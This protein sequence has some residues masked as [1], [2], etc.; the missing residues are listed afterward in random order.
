[1]KKSKNRGSKK[2]KKVP[3]FKYTIL[4]IG[5]FLVLF[6]GLAINTDIRTFLTRAA[7]VTFDQ[8]PTQKNKRLD[9]GNNERSEIV[10]QSPTPTLKPGTT[11]GP[12]PDPINATVTPKPVPT[13]GQEVCRLDG[14]TT[15]NCKCQDMRGLK[16]AGENTSYEFEGTKYTVPNFYWITPGNDYTDP[17]GMYLGVK[18]S[19][20][21]RQ[22][23]ADYAKK[24]AQS[25][26]VEWCIGKPVIYLYPQVPTLVDVAIEVPGRIFISD[27]EYPEGGWKNV[28]AYPN[29]NLIFEG[30]KYRDLYYETDLDTDL[31][32]PAN[33]ILIPVEQ[34]E[35]KLLT[36]TQKLGLN[37]FESSE[38]VEY[39]VPLL[40]EMNSPYVLFSILDNAEKERIDT[41]H[42]SPKPDTF[43]AFLA[44]FKPVYLFYTPKPLVLPNEPQERNGFTAVEWGG[45]IDTEAI[46]E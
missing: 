1:M 32:I 30:K 27:P 22:S 43:I 39:W 29:G 42:I 38:F 17:V 44:Y 34:L 20:I 14:K 24:K 40:E 6:S 31:R 16:C 12:S 28:L 35:E 26:C 7:D 33:G 2:V 15:E 41:V 23:A 37:E 11:A 36:Y 46:R 18:G 8:S 5:V 13:G 3:Y 45:T 19:W 10:P 25:N 4:A 9:P 21:L